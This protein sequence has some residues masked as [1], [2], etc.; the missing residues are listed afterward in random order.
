M[1][2]LFLPC[3]HRH[4]PL[5]INR[6]RFYLVTTEDITSRGKFILWSSKWF[7]AQCQRCRRHF[8]GLR[9][10][11]RAHTNIWCTR[12]Y[13]A[14]DCPKIQCP[15]PY[16]YRGDFNRTANLTNFDLD[17]PCYRG[18]LTKLFSNSGYVDESHVLWMKTHWHASFLRYPRAARKSFGSPEMNVLEMIRVRAFFS[19]FLSI[20][21]VYRFER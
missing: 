15:R 17:T 19:N 16:R 8:R 14:S 18:F 20:K 1:L 13:V 12:T 7:A 5:Y 21:C 4:V 2:D 10:L 9:V 3:G 6:E 11:L